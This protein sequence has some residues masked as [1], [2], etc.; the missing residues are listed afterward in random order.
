MINVQGVRKLFG[1]NGTSPATLALD[2]LD[3]TVAAHEFVC[4]VGPSGCGK[5]TVLKVLA[6]LVTPDAG[7]VTIN[8]IR[9]TAPGAD[10]AMVFQQPALLPW[11][12][13]L[14]AVAFGLQLRGMPKAERDTIARDLIRT[15]GLSGFEQHYPRQLSGGMQQRVGLARA[16]AVNPDILLMDEP[17]AATDAQTRRSLQEELLRLHATLR[18]TV[19]FV[20]HDIDEAVRLGDRVLLMSPR[21]GR[22]RETVVVSAPRPRSTALDSD[23]ES[24]RLK[25]YLWWQLQDGSS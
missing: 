17:F 2:R 5:T 6:G 24:A 20:T 21:P 12:N 11:A 3:F 8:G 22:I 15:V 9:V 23:A 16:L 7:E 14:T 19:V 13:V 18:K 4:L 25:A 10:R 1:G